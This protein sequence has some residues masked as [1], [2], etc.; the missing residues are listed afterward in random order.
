MI[1]GYLRAV[2]ST[3]TEVRRQLIYSSKTLERFRVVTVNSRE[4]D[5][6]GHAVLHFA[7]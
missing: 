4:N 2:I 7:T 3:L 6:A 5:P 1:H